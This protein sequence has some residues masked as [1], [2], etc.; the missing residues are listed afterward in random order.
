[1]P[2]AAA[3]ISMHVGHFRVACAM[4]CSCDEGNCPMENQMA[5]MLTPRLFRSPASCGSPAAARGFTRKSRAQE[6]VTAAA[7][8]PRLRLVVCAPPAGL[9]THDAPMPIL[10]RELASQL[11]VERYAPA[12]AARRLRTWVSAT[13]P[14]LLL[15]RDGGIVAVAV[16][17][18]SRL[19]L[20]RLIR[21]AL[22]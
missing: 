18:L 4:R 10:D 21:H 20:E 6:M 19:E 9:A 14:T 11:D 13:Q 16:G 1:M 5:S 2:S 3:P 15:L 7:V 17:V 8:R 12:E 22:L